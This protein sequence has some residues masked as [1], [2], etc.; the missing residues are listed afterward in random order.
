MLNWCRSSTNTSRWAQTV[1]RRDLDFSE[2]VCVGEKHTIL[3]SMADAELFP[4]HCG[5]RITYDPYSTDTTKFPVGFVSPLCQLLPCNH[6]Y[7]QFIRIENTAEVFEQTGEKETASAI[8][9]RLFTGKPGG[10]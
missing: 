5:S 8:A 2:G 7:Q 9:F 1:I 3:F 10:S 6:I 4:S